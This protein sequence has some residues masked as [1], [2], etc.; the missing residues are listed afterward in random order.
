MIDEHMLLPHRW[1]RALDVTRA[2]LALACLLVEVLLAE[3]SSTL[4]RL[5]LVFFLAYAFLAPFWENLQRGSRVL[6]SLVV[7]SI[8]FL[9]CATI[10]TE[11]T[12]WLCTAFFLFLMATAVLLHNWKQVLAVMAICL[13]LVPLIRPEDASRLWPTFLVAGLLALL[14]C[15]QRQ[16]LVGRLI[17][18]SRQAVLFRSE[19]QKAREA[20]RERIAADFHDGPLQSFI[21]LQLRLE[22][23]KKL[24]ERDPD[25]A[26]D[27]LLQLRELSKAQVAEVRAFVRSMRP[28]EVDGVSLTAAISR[29]VDNFQKDTG[30][31]A[32]F[33][34]GGTLDLDDPEIAGELLKI[35]REALHNAQKHSGASRVA[36]GLEKVDGAVEILIQDDG[37]GFDFSGTYSLEELDLLRLGPESIKR[38][39]RTLG[40]ELVVES[41]PGFG[42]GLKIRIPA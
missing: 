8:F 25:S 33:L 7:D 42:A 10:R 24:L 39:V 13:G 17:R 1:H 34:G 20:E 30:I 31:S 22:I 23:V 2:L 18:S 32:T 19:S 38:R 11:H 41:R 16:S 35:V 37:S 28:V 12:I 14:A 6:L 3:P 40:G 4:N 29:L 36:V 5:L 27:E 15:R 9:V 21:S 26:M